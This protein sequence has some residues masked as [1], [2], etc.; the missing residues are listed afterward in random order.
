VLNNL[1][2]EHLLLF[3]I[4]RK[5]NQYMSLFHKSK[6]NTLWNPLQ[7]IEKLLFKISKLN[8]GGCRNVA[9]DVQKNNDSYN[10]I[11]TIIIAARCRIGYPPREEKWQNNPGRLPLVTSGDTLLLASTQLDCIMEGAIVDKTPESYEYS[12]ITSTPSEFLRLTYLGCH[13]LSFT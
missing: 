2:C 13:H 12:Y 3:F 4:F 5:W 8:R 1:K 9:A 11:R 6:V 10:S 7:K